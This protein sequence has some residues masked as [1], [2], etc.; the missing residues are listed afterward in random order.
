MFIIIFFLFYHWTIILVSYFLRIKVNYCDLY[1]E[2][3]QVKLLLMGLYDHIS[4][5]QQNL[6]FY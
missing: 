3:F 5:E 6:I 1:D 2:I 4:S